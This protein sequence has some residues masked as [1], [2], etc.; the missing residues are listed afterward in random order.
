MNVIFDTLSRR[1]SL[2]SSDET[3]DYNAKISIGETTAR[4]LNDT[5][6]FRLA[7]AAWKKNSL[8]HVVSLG[9]RALDAWKNDSEE[10]RKAY[11]RKDAGRETRDRRIFD[12]CGSSL[13]FHVPRQSDQLI[14]IY[15]VAR[16]PLF[17]PICDPRS[18]FYVLRL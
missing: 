8:R 14:R 16:L 17:I 4:S 5:Y 12:H 3:E 11:L 1:P 6:E 18:A 10:G 13:G 9:P 7:R 2:Y 15:P